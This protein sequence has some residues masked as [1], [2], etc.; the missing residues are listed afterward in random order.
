MNSSPPTPQ[1]SLVP[2]DH[3]SLP[4]PYVAP[5]TPTEQRL[6]EIWRK[7]L[8]MDRVGI[9]DNYNDLGGD[10]FVA[11]I[12]G[13][14]IEEIFRVAIPMGILADAPTI[15]DLARRIDGLLAGTPLDN[16]ADSFEH[17]N[18]R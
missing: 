17:A 10:S 2:R 4:R 1:E 13:R 15:A 18:R 6:A 7:T 12:I 5:R 14:T 16:D 8:S 11:T 9:E 3:L